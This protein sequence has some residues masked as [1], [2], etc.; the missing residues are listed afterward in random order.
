MERMGSSFRFIGAGGT[1]EP[2]F[3]I[4]PAY[5]YR[6][7]SPVEASFLGNIV[8][9]YPPSCPWTQGNSVAE[10]ESFLTAKAYTVIP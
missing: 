5:C 7:V 8:P 4:Y 6:Q 2:I 9:E 1:S 10:D 3:R